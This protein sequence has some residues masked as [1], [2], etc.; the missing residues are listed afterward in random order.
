MP[1]NRSSCRGVSICCREK[2]HQE[3]K[4]LGQQCP[5]PWGVEGKRGKGLPEVSYP[6]PLFFSGFLKHRALVFPWRYSWEYLGHRCVSLPCRRGIA[7]PTTT[8]LGKEEWQCIGS[9]AL[10]SACNQPGWSSL[11]WKSLLPPFKKEPTF[12][13]GFSPFSCFQVSSFSRSFSVGL[14]GENQ[15]H[16]NAEF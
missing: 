12:S 1:P 8:V 14:V 10:L 11:R 15:C 7:C 3:E 16:A 9:F 2:Q 4:L 6:T 13:W 5:L